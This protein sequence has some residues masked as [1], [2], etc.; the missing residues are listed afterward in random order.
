MEGGDLR[1][2]RKGSGRLD[3]WHTTRRLDLDI[4]AEV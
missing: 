3:V 2:W 1:C 4:S